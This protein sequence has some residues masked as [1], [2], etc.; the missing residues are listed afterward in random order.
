MRPLALTTP[1]VTVCSKPKG[2]PMAMAH[3]PTSSLSETPQ[4]ATGRSFDLIWRTARSVLG[5]WPFTVAVNSLPSFSCTLTLSAPSTTWL[6][7]R[8][9]P[10]L[11]TMTPDPPLLCFCRNSFPL[12]RG[13]P[14]PLKKSSKGLPLKKSSPNLSQGFM[15]IVFS[16]VTLTTAGWTFLAT[17]TKAWPRDLAVVNLSVL[18]S[19]LARLLSIQKKR[20]NSRARKASPKTDRLIIFLYIAHSLKYLYL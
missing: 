10:S 12:S 6:L 11:S 1:T 7:V 8:I 5:S 17:S 4:M 9:Y 13:D 18:G 16:V 14:K 20:P 3:S 19:E 15:V 2:L